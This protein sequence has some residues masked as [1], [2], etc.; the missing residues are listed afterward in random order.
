MVLMTVS[1]FTG[2]GEGFMRGCFKEK[3]LQVFAGG[4][5]VIGL[6]TV[7][8]AVFLVSME[9]KKRKRLGWYLVFAAYLI[10]IVAFAT[11]VLLMSGTAGESPVDV[12]YVKK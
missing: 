4:L 2:V 11:L 1:V 9:G 6:L 8:L 10:P 5:C 12:S 3:T 7:C